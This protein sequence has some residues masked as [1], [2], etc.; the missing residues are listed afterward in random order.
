M[1]FNSKGMFSEANQKSS[2]LLNKLRELSEQGKYP[3]LI[4]TSPCKLMLLDNKDK[5]SGLSIFEPVGFIE[6]VLIDYLDFSPVDD[7]VMLHVTC[8]SRTMGLSSKMEQLAQRC[9]TQVIVPENIQCCGFA[10]DKGFTTPE[11]NENALAPLKAQVP[12]NCNSGY[13]NSRTC[14]IGLSE[15]SGI[16]YQSI[17]YLVDKA[18]SVKVSV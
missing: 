2:A 8:S 4:D 18:T 12:S 17:I 16:D 10:G 9:S 3:I 13:S 7:P 5:V 15:H 14:E 6:D 11:L 1:P